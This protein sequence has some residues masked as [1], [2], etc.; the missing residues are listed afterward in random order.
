MS[1]CIFCKIINKDIPAKFVYEDNNVVAFNDLHPDASEHYLF[2]HRTHQVN[3]NASS[4]ELNVISDV[5]SAI[6]KFTESNDLAK[7]GFRVVTNS[8]K[9]SHQSVFHTHF[10]VLGGESLGSFGR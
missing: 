1:D 6:K 5:F 7:N 8:G 10:H 9:H 2:I 3:V 4:A